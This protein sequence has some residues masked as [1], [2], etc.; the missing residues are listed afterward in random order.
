L[1]WPSHFE[2]DLERH[3]ASIADNLS[4]N[5][6][7]RW[8]EKVGWHVDHTKI[9]HRKASTSA[10][11]VSSDDAA[12]QALSDFGRVLA[13]KLRSDQREISALREAVDRLKADVEKL[14]KTRDS[15]AENCRKAQGKLKELRGNRR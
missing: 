7:Q 15:W 3:L 6:I 2:D 12:K 4:G 11:C 1:G 8:L 5:E 9:V 14:K 10:E 13:A